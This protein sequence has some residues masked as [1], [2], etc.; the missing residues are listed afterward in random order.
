MTKTKFKIEGK[1]TVDGLDLKKNQKETSNK[2]ISSKKIFKIL[3]KSFKK[4]SI[5][6]VK[7]ITWNGPTEIAVE[8]IDLSDAKKWDASKDGAKGKNSVD[9]KANKM[10]EQGPVNQII[11]LKS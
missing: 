6:W 8:D 7:E 9:K 5:Q 2:Q 11:L 10:D 4:K 1:I 3:S